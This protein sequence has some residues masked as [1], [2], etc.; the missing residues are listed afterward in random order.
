MN[1]LK[2]PQR[3]KLSLLL[4]SVKYRQRQTIKIPE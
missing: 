3:D 4:Q 1:A 2:I